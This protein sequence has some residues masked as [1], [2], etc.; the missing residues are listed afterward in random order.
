MGHLVL[1]SWAWKPD[2]QRRMTITIQHAVSQ[3]K[4][5]DRKMGRIKSLMIIDFPR[6]ADGNLSRCHALA[7]PLSGP[8]ESIACCSRLA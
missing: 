1:W 4:K 3:P 2:S 7:T 5:T 6:Y 8:S